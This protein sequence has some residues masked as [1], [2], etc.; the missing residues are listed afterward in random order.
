MQ[1]VQALSKSPKWCCSEFVGARKT[2]RNAIC[3]TIAH[4]VQCKI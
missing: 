1:E 3:Q 2:L 4:M